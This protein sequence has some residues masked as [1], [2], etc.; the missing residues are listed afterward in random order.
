MILKKNGTNEEISDKENKNDQTITGVAENTQQAM[1]YQKQRIVNVSKIFFD[2]KRIVKNSKALNIIR[3][4]N[5]SKTDDKN[6]NINFS[7][8]SLRSF[9]TSFFSDIDIY[10]FGKMFGK[11][12]Q[13]I[14]VNFNGNEFAK[15]SNQNDSKKF[16][17]VRNLGQ[18]N[19][20]KVNDILSII[21]SII[22][23]LNDD[24]DDT[25]NKQNEMQLARIILNT[26]KNGFGKMSSNALEM[27]PAFIQASPEKKEKLEFQFKSFMFLLTIEI[28]RRP[29]HDDSKFYKKTIQAGKQQETML[30]FEFMFFNLSLVLLLIK[31][32]ILTF[33]EAFNHNSKYCIFT[34]KKLRNML[35]DE[36]SEKLNN[37]TTLYIKS[38]Y[39]S[40]YKQALIEN[41]ALFLKQQTI[42]D[43]FIQ[44][45]SSE[46]HPETPAKR[47]IY[48]TP[49]SSKFIT[50][51]DI[52][53]SSPCSTKTHKIQKNFQIARDLNFDFQSDDSSNET[54]DE[55]PL[56]ENFYSNKKPYFHNNDLLINEPKKPKNEF[57]NKMSSLNISTSKINTDDGDYETTTE[58]KKRTRSQAEKDSELIINEYPL[59]KQKLK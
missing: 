1:L 17:Y 56:R 7:D 48:K 19:D 45:S 25:L 34:S 18:Y 20:A 35:E 8:C 32:G 57:L 22:E 5:E 33:K 38:F 49:Q 40:E 21:Y 23:P 55:D 31:K 11:K 26:F 14:F 53:T 46:D 58:H 39:P 47:R 54:E 59:K 27:F 30:S 28:F 44:V 51:N 13:Q 4:F 52:S 10:F 12:F 16:Q 29:N 9:L 36:F 6:R 24:P 2:I 37:L 3:E 43:I 50:E 42:Y 41:K 15:V